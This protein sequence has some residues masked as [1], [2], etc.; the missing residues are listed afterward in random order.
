MIRGLRVISRT[1]AMQFK[2][3]R[4]SAPEIAKTLGVDALVEG[5]VIRQGDRIRVHAQLIRASTDEHFW[6]ETYDRDLSDVLAL[7]SNVAQAIADQVEVSLSNDERSRLVAARQVSPVVYESYLKGRS[8]VLNTE[9]DGQKSIAY[10]E[11]A[12]KKDPTFAP[13]YVGLAAAYFQVSTPAGG[14]PPRSVQPKLISAARKALELDSTL[15]EPHILL[16]LAYQDQWEWRL[17]N[18]RQL[19]HLLVTRQLVEEIDLFEP[20]GE[21]IALLSPVEIGSH[22][23]TSKANPCRLI[24]CRRRRGSGISRRKFLLQQAR[25]VEHHLNI[26]IS[27]RILSRNPEKALPITSHRIVRIVVRV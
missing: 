26:N 6:P 7:Q 21:R 15:P 20:L 2:D 12:I 16:A 25:P 5:S 9:A 4:L 11:E 23:P 18:S 24:V 17:P 8:V 10:V 3:T 19:G 27:R 14:V 22:K 1:S 13:A